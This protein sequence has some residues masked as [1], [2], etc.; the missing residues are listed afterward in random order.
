MD[1]P[2]EHGS[3]PGSIFW[4]GQPGRARFVPAD[5]T[6]SGEA[7]EISP[8]AALVP[9]SVPP[10]REAVR[11]AVPIVTRIVQAGTHYGRSTVEIADG[12]ACIRNVQC[13]FGYSSLAWAGP[14]G[15]L[16]GVVYDPNAGT[17]PGSA[18]TRLRC[19]LVPSPS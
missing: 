12:T 8:S 11:V 10:R 16:T 4:V 15:A 2:A 3:V 19:S 18:A 6:L 9:C 1:S 17:S 14:G 13:V 7:V 5:R